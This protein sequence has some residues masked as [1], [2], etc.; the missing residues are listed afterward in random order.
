[1]VFIARGRKER[2]CITPREV[3]M[4]HSLLS[5]AHFKDALAQEMGCVDD[6]ELRDHLSQRP[7]KPRNVLKLA[8]D[9]IPAHDQLNYD[10]RCTYGTAQRTSK[11]RR[12]MEKEEEMAIR[13]SNRNDKKKAALLKVH[14]QSL[15][16][17]PTR[18]ADQAT[19]KRTRKRTKE[20]T[21]QEKEASARKGSAVKK[22]GCPGLL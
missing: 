17:S 5:K 7:G 12:Q 20:S 4:V 15:T 13:A 8:D 19:G 10:L 16:P 14:G 2:F 22:R 9:R 11:S 21:H 3:T 1:M 6:E 18:D